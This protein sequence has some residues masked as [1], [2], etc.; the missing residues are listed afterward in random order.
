MTAQSE[1]DI[2]TCKQCGD[3]FIAMSSSAEF[4]NDDC[5]EVARCNAADDEYQREMED[6]EPC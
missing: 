1:P 5:Q 6:D 2:K 4:C 3:E